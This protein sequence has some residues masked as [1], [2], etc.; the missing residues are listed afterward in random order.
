[1]H[2]SKFKKEFN[3]LLRYL[4]I[5]DNFSFKCQQCGD[6]CRH[7]SGYV[8]IFDKEISKIAKFLKITTNDFL[9]KYCFKKDGNY[10]LKEKENMDCIFWNKDVNCEIYKFRPNQCKN[11][12]FWLTNFISEKSLIKQS[13]NCKGFFRGKKIYTRKQIEEKLYKDFID[14]YDFYHDLFKDLL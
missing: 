9:S 12:P 11:Y 3:F 1:M 5:P 6:C 14:R 2:L 4:Y 13:E 7:E 10:S 8:W